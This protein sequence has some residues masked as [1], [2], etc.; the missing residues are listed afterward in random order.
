MS[1]GSGRR[2]IE[3]VHP[4]LKNTTCVLS[5]GLRKEWAK[6]ASYWIELFAR[7]LP[8]GP[9]RKSHLL[10]IAQQWSFY[11]KTTKEQIEDQYVL[12]TEWVSVNNAVGDL[13]DRIKG[14]IQEK[15]EI[16][17]EVCFSDGWED[18]ATDLKV[19]L[20][21]KDPKAGHGGG[22]KLPPKEKTI[23]E[24]FKESIAE[25]SRKAKW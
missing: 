14:R 1:I 18:V 23:A 16:V 8:L 11:R 4:S 9:R 13:V 5:V 20:S 10:L 3:T 17:A 19:K 21:T 25:R 7:P 22:V 6:K 24:K 12:P 15:D 2:P